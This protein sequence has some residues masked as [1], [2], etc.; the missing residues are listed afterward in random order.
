MAQEDGRARAHR[1]W[2]GL[3]AEHARYK[4]AVSYLPTDKTRLQEDL[5]RYLCLRCAGFLERVTEEIL[6]EFLYRKSS[7]P[8]LD[9][10]RSHL[11]VPNLRYDP[12]LKL[13]GRFGSQYE[14]SFAAV[15]TGPTKEALDDLFGVRNLIAHGEYQGGRRLDPE[16]YMRLAEEIYDWLVETFLGSSAVVLADDGKTRLGTV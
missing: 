6:H 7:S 11:Y 13:V 10:A 9:F 4:E 2:T 14:E 5:R 16:R 8:I 3:Q 12:F 15:L 1:L